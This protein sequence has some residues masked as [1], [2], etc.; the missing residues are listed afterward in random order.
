[1]HPV[2]YNQCGA[3]H[4][5]GQQL[6][7]PQEHEQAPSQVNKGGSGLDVAQPQTSKHREL[8]GVVPCHL[9]LFWQELSIQ[10]MDAVMAP[11]SRWGVQDCG[12]VL[13]EYCHVVVED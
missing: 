2:C 6:V 3:H 4:E 10:V 5:A 12:H 7:L 9:Q 8:E 11:H 13:D 1:V